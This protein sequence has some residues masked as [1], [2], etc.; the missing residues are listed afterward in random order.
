[1]KWDLIDLIAFAKAAGWLPAGLKLSDGWDWKKAGVGD[2]AE[3]VRMVRNLAHPARYLKDHLRG[4]VTRKYLQRQFGFVLSCRDWLA[5]QNN[6]E[7]LCAS[8]RSAPRRNR[9]RFEGRH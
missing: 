3:V 5:A 2:L 8:A 4:R 9:R 6:R 7:L 1:L